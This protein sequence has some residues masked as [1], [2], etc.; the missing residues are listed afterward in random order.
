MVTDLFDDYEGSRAGAED[1]KNDHVLHAI[2][3]YESLKRFAQT[4]AATP[5][6]NVKR[7]K[8]Q[9]WMKDPYRRAP[10]KAQYWPKPNTRARRDLDELR[11]WLLSHSVEIGGMNAD[12]TAYVFPIRIPSELETEDG[13][14]NGSRNYFELNEAGI[15]NADKDAT[16]NAKRGSTAGAYDDLRTFRIHEQAWDEDEDEVLSKYEAHGLFH[17]ERLGA[18][19][20]LERVA[21]GLSTDAELPVHEG[22]DYS[23]KYVP[24]EGHI[25]YDGR[26]MTQP[27]DRTPTEVLPYYGL[28]AVYCSALR[29]RGERYRKL[30]ERQAKRLRWRGMEEYDAV[31]KANEKLREGVARSKDSSNAKP[32]PDIGRLHELFRLQGSDLINR[33]LGRVVTG[34]KVKV[35]GQLYQTSRIAYALATG[36]DPADKMVRNGT[37]SHYRK[38]EGHAAQRG[39]GNWDAL[40]WLG[41]DRVTIGE[42]QTEEQAKEACRLY[43]KSLDMGL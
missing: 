14:Q 27:V 8:I 43:L 12:G 7:R 29:K 31:E 39:D 40:V 28:D 4:M 32:L 35:E 16:A 10:N 19:E 3:S 9:G 37:A 17:V 36:E 5:V 20:S 24:F 38:A 15:R 33:R 18:N 41:K 42:Y 11:S 6:D 23:P 26:P 25:E 34:R 13:K 22:T 2:T 1:L 21:V 30:A